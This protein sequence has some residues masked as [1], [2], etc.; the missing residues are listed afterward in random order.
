MNLRENELV[1]RALS[2]AIQHGGKDLANVPELLKKV[3]REES[4]RV[5]V[6]DEL[7]GKMVEFGRFEEF[8]TTPPLEGMGATIKMIK[9]LVRDDPEAEKML[10][11]AVQRPHGGDQSKSDN[12]TLAPTPT[13][14]SRQKALRRLRKDRPDLLKRV[15]G[16][17]LSPHGAMLVAGFRKPPTPLML[18]RRAWEKAS[19]DERLIFFGEIVSVRP[20]PPGWEGE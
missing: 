11:A 9:N 12:V 16:G 14:N 10:D 20:P 4:W 13:G 17:E 2:R 5:R 15:E 18:L 8:V 1:A 6:I 7:D 3:L 19:E